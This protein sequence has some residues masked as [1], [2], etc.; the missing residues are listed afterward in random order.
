MKILYSIVFLLLTGC[1]SVDY[2]GTMTVK[3]ISV[4]ATATYEETN[5]GRDPIIRIKYKL[6]GDEYSTRYMSSFGDK[7]IYKP[8][9]IVVFNESKEAIQNYYFEGYE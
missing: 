2:S 9:S 7:V 6:E 5:K 1:S 4:P 8:R 3:G